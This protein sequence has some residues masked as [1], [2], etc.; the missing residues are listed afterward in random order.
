MELKPCPFCGK[1]PE[2]VE[3]WVSQ[4]IH[5]GGFAWVVRCNYL[6][7]GCG[8]KSGTRLEKEEAIELW[9]KRTQRND[10]E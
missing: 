4:G 1:K 9:N 10:Y 2:C 6:N 3:E 5:E 7:G 8:G